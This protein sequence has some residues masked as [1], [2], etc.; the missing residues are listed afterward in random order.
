[1]P[2]DLI[3]ADYLTFLKGKG[4]YKMVL[5]MIDTFSNFVLAYRLKLAGTGKTTLNSLRNLVLHYQKPDTIMTDGGLHFNN[6]EVQGY[7][8]AQDIRHITTPEYAP[9]MNSLIENTNKILLG[10]LRRIC[11]PNLD[12]MEETGTGPSPTPEKWPDHLEEA[13]RAMNNRI[14]LAVG[15]TPREWLWGR[16]ETAQERKDEE[17]TA[18]TETDIEHHLIL[19]DLLR[20]QGYTDTLMEAANRKRRFDG[21]V[22]PVTFVTGDLVQV[23]DSKLY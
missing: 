10:R 20:S 18:R 11:T 3:S 16:R 14:L 9:W 5:L 6:E 23:Y 15:L 21:K 12:E 8:E 22:R 2:F 19:V 13:I 17:T 7:C 4:G 1:M